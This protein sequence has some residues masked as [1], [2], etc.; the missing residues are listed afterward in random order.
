[1]VRVKI[2][3]ITNLADAQLSAELGAQAIGLNFYPESPRVISPF[4]A[5][6]IVDKLP[7]FVSAVGIFVNWAPEAV[8]A[9]SL[10]LRLSY[11]QLHGDETARIVVEVARKIAVIKALRAGPGCPPLAFSKYRPA[12]AFLLDAARAGEFGGT[13]QST[14]WPLA[15]KAAAS[16]RIILA[17]GLTPENVADAIAA[18]RP[19]AVDV[20]S[21]VESRPGKKDPGKL[22]AFFEEVKRANER[23]SVTPDPDPFIGTWELDPSTLDYEFGRPGRR[24][25]YVIE[26]IPGG[27]QFHLDADDADGKPL[28]FTYGGQLDGRE[29]PIRAAG[30]VLVLTRIN[31]NYIESTLRRDGTIVDRWTREMLPGGKTMRIVQFGNKPNGEEFR[32]ASLYQR[33]K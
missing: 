28:N 2:C 10:A 14:D 18:V 23:L 19:H 30:A 22:R 33:T 32:N 27:L 8:I 12:S 9:L 17:G 4:A 15:R 29:Q 3:G 7:P 11:A 16:H 1:M 21:G 26:S 31:E 13:G 6:K 25:T 20:A 24:A 5:G